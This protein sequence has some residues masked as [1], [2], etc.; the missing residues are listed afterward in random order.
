M[1]CKRLKSENLY[2]RKKGQ[3]MNKL[4]VEAVKRLG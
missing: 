1:I 2:L 3:A 4:Q